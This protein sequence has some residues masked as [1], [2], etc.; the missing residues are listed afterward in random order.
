MGFQMSDTSW[1]AVMAQ[2]AAAQRDFMNGDA[3][4]L[5]NLYSHRDDVTVMG[6]FG[7]F[8][9]GWTEVG[10]RLAWAASHF[11]GGDYS[12]QDISATVGA[13]VACLVC[14]ERWARVAQDGQ[15]IPVMELRVTQTFRLE[16]DRWRL[17]H[18][19]ADELVQKREPT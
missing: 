15:P 10:P 2:L 17:V 4:G 12:Q 13:D 5:Q 7:G 11:H 9:H 19:H 8:E 6:G 16:G 3:T 14:L 18:R 1:D